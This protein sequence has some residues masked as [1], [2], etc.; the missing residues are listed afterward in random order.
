[1]AMRAPQVRRAATF[2]T[3][4][5]ALREQHAEIDDAIDA[6]CEALV[7]GYREASSDRI[8]GHNP[9]VY[10]HRV[11][12]PPFGGRGRGRFRVTFLVKKG[13]NPMRDPDVFWLLTIQ[14]AAAILN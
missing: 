6:F 13:V 3:D 11:D 7:L 14:I 10:A 9:P 5:E 4:L 2:E 8:P 1:M 12:Y